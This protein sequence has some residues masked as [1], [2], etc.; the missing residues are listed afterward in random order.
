MKKIIIR[1]TSEKAVDSFLSG[2]RADLQFPTSRWG[3]MW[4][5]IA[6]EMGSTRNKGKRM[7]QASTV[8]F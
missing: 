8:D 1:E 4:V 5:R 3:Q 6:G 7:N 2:S